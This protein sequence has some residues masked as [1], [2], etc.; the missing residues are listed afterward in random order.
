MKQ[1]SCYWR[2]YFLRLS[3]RHLRSIELGGAKAEWKEDA[4]EG[5]RDI[6]TAV[7][8]QHTAISRI[9]ADLAS[10]ATSE[11]GALG[12][13]SPKDSASSGEVPAQQMV[14]PL[15]RILWVDDKPES[16]AF[17]LASLRKLFTVDVATTTSEALKRLVAE[18]YEAVISDIVR[19]EGGA[20]TCMRVLG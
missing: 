4:S 5:L 12:P 16:N 20:R 17:E 10:Q 15:R 11:D 8:E 6:L 7:K 3:F 14:R 18:D 19:V 13:P 9:Y 2:Y 1:A